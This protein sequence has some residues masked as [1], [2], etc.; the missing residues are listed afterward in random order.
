MLSCAAGTLI[1]VA[2]TAHSIPLPL[3]IIQTT[4]PR[5]ESNKHHYL[6]FCLSPYEFKIE[7]CS[8]VHL[9][10][11]IAQCGIVTTCFASSCRQSHLVELMVY[12]PTNLTRWGENPASVCKGKGAFSFFTQ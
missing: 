5:Q 12:L 7:C 9:Q 10:C 8:N 2:S 11:R 6:V 3:C 4:P 1:K